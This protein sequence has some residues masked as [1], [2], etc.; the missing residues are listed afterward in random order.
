V[1]AP[2]IGTGRRAASENV[3][4][5]SEGCNR[6]LRVQRYILAELVVTLALTLLVVTSVLFAAL[7]LQTMGRMEGLDLAFLLKLLPPLLPLAIAF[8]MPFA[9]LLAVALVYGRLVSDREL[10]ALRIAGVHPRVAA[11]PA[12]TLGAVL[13]L[14]S[15][16]FT[17]WA[18]PDGALALEQQK[19]NLA[20][21]FLANLSTSQH[22]VT[23]PKCRLSW[24]RYE[25]SRRAGEAGVFRDFEL[26]F[27]DGNDSTKILGDE[28]RLVR[29]DDGGESGGEAGDS[30]DEKHGGDLVV[31]APW[32]YVIRVQGTGGV[33]TSVARSYERKI[34]Y[35][36]SLG[37]STGFNQLVG[38]QRV[39]AKSRQVRLPDVCYL[40]HRGD[41]SRVPLRRSLTE[42]H[43]RLATAA[44]PLLFALVAVGVCFQF[45]PRTRRMTGFLLA[46]LPI[47][48]VHL[49]LWVSG[50]NFSDA[51]R[52]PAWF[53]MWLPD[54][55]LL[56][57][58]TGL[59]SRAYRR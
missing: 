40:I 53:G 3:P 44:M 30:D 26:D 1:S 24:D 46:S 23:T 42:L 47:L 56:V 33:S 17:G 54:A 49:P 45:S 41:V 28:L 20:D 14:A 34:G 12:L 16:L 50:K 43:G 31:E 6:V 58:G 38:A 25:P 39:E 59:F 27:R 18:L 48:L 8:S 52:V 2:E 32:A 4:V 29:R 35:V 55:A 13:S 9:Y 7:C 22:A 37:A 10:I 11:A 57:V 19:A 36:E 51:G 15:L 21:Q 5:G